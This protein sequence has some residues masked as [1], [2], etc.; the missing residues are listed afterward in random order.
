M[1]A[2]I[3]AI[4]KR[5]G[6]VPWNTENPNVKVIPQHSLHSE[7]RL[8]LLEFSVLLPY[9]AMFKEKKVT[10]FLMKDRTFWYC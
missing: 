3:D 9:F 2:K 5:R 10:Q 8:L 6:F 1:V 7:H 4:N